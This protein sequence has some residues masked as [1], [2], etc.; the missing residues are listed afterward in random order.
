MPNFSLMTNSEVSDIYLKSQLASQIKIL[1]KST[2]ID[3]DAVVLCTGA[4]TPRFLKDV[5]KLGCPILPVKSYSF[6]I[7]TEY[8]PFMFSFDAFTAVWLK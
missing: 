1:G 5:L 7:P 3:T 8:P 4:S 6:D 2:V